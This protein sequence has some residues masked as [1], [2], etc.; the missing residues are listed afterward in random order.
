MGTDN[1]PNQGRLSEVQLENALSVK[2]S[3]DSIH[4]FCG[5]MAGFT[6]FIINEY[7]NSGGYASE[8][9]FDADG[10]AVYK[11]PFTGTFKWGLFLLVMSFSMNLAAAVAAFLWGVFLREGTYREWFMI[12]VGRSAKLLATGGLFS[13]CVGVLMFVDTIGLDP[14]FNYVVN[15][16]AAL[17][18]SL[19][20]IGFLYTMVVVAGNTPPEDWMQVMKK[21]N[22]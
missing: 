7:V 10:D 5:L 20:G 15:V 11:E 14:W 13:F 12:V 18:F 2:E 17:A 21:I 1:T 22:G 9:P 8:V 3:M 16:F 6:G 4:S 19:I